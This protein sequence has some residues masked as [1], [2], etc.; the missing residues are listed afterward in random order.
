MLASAACSDKKKKGKSSNGVAG[1]GGLTGWFIPPPY[2]GSRW[3]SRGGGQGGG[4]GGRNLPAK[5]PQPKPGP[6]VE[7]VERPARVERAYAI[8]PIGAN[9]V[10]SVGDPEPAA[11]VTNELVC[12]ATVP[13]ELA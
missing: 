1:T 12:E 11:T 8:C 2:H 3:V 10:T 7:R 4:Q 6:S 5:R 9:P 13:S